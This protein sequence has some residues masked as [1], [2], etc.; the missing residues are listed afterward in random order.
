MHLLLSSPFGTYSDRD[1]E[2]S[3]RSAVEERRSL[4]MRR[5]VRSHRR[6]ASPRSRG[7]REYSRRARSVRSGPAQGAERGNTFAFEGRGGQ[8]VEI[9]VVGGDANLVGAPQVDGTLSHR[10][11]PPVAP[12]RV[13]GDPAGLAALSG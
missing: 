3:G 1:A 6:L 5:E 13:V 10:A 2:A 7:R 11:P 12:V 4:T 9:A 8:G